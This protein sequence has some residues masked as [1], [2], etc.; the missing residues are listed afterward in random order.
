MQAH[1]GTANPR[2]VLAGRADGAHGELVLDVVERAGKLVTD[3]VDPVGDVL[4]QQFEQRGAVHG[5]GIAGLQGGPGSLDRAQGMMA[6]CHQ[7]PV[8]HEEVQVAHLVAGAMDLPHQVG[9][10]AVDAVPRCMELLVPVVR[11]HRG[12]RRLRQPCR[13]QPE[14]GRHLGEIEVQP[15]PALMGDFD[16]L[17]EGERAGVSLVVDPEAADQ[18]RNDAEAQH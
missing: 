13:A 11:E 9:Q 2:Q 1:R 4:D 5:P 17:I 16:G 8:G 15:Q 18:P 10:D 6:T 12:H 3:I 14:G 7:Q